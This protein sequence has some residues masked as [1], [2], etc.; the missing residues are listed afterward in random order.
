LFRLASLLLLLSLLFVLKST[1]TLC[2]GLLSSRH[3]IERSRP[4]EPRLLPSAIEHHSSPI[5]V[6]FDHRRLLLSVFVTG[7]EFLRR[8]RISNAS[9]ERRRSKTYEVINEFST[10]LFNTLERRPRQRR[11]PRPTVDHP[12]ISRELVGEPNRGELRGIDVRRH[13]DKTKRIG[14]V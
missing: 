12:L 4:L 3:Q 11:I 6:A 9:N 5:V 2:D 10:P 8:Q 1:I 13:R 14:E 7:K